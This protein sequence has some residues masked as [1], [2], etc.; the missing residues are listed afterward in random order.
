MANGYYAE[1]RVGELGIEVATLKDRIKA[2]EDDLAKQIK[3]V[4]ELEVRMDLNRGARA[5]QQVINEKFVEI[6][7][8]VTIRAR[9][10]YIIATLPYVAA[11]IAAI[12][13]WSAK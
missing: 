7:D 2:M 6:L 10:V 3:R 5:Q 8:S 13:V 9:K 11:L 1:K 12:Y 4:E